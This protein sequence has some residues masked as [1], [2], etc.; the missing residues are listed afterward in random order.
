MWILRA[1]VRIALLQ[2]GS[3]L[4]PQGTAK[5][6]KM[7]K[8]WWAKNINDFYVNFACA[9]QDRTFP[10][11]IRVGTPRDNQRNENRKCLMSKK[12]KQLLC[13]FYGIP[14]GFHCCRQGPI[15]ASILNPG[16][17]GVFWNSENYKRVYRVEILDLIDFWQDLYRRRDVS[18]QQKSVGFK[19]ELCMVWRRPCHNISFRPITPSNK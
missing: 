8:F 16:L 12:H 5:G 17:E 2:Q 9:F 18:F 1:P 7:E 19:E 3:K 6:M 13:E 4:G 15:W 14:S 11:R 10:A